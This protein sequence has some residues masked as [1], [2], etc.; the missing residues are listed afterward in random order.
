MSWERLQLRVQ[1]LADG[2]SFELDGS[3]GQAFKMQHA[4]RLDCLGFVI[5]RDGVRLGYTGDA[6][7][8]PQLDALIEASDHVISEMTYDDEGGELHGAVMARDF[9]T[10]Q[11]PLH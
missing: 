1:E 3:R 6:E 4:S 10:L 7:M 9:L 2:D 8:S 11:L 5:E